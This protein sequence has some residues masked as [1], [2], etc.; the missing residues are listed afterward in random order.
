MS[1]VFRGVLESFLQTNLGCA[2]ATNVVSAARHSHGWLGGLDGVRDILL[3]LSES[4]SNTT[5]QKI[6]AW[7]TNEGLRLLPITVSV[8][9]ANGPIAYS[10]EG[11]DQS[12]GGDQRTQFIGLTLCALAHETRD[13]TAVQLF[14]SCILQPL[15]EGASEIANAVYAQLNDD[16]NIRRILNEGA[17]RGLTQ[18]FLSVAS[19][20]NLPEGDREWLGDNLLGDD[21]DLSSLT[22]GEMIGGM[23]KWLVSEDEGLYTTRSALVCR[24]ALYLQ[25]I[26][27]RIGSVQAMN[28]PGDFLSDL[29]PKSV[30]LVTK[31]PGPADQLILRAGEI[32][33]FSRTLH[34]RFK[35]AG[36]MLLTA[37]ESQMD[38]DPDV[39][40]A[41]F[42]HIQGYVQ[43]HF[44][45]EY[46]DKGSILTGVQVKLRKEGR[47]IR[48][49][50]TAKK[51]AAIYFPNTAK[52]FAPCYS[53]IESEELLDEARQTSDMILGYDVIPDE[54][55]LFRAVT[56][57]IVIAF[58]GKM[59]GETFSESQHSISLNLGSPTWLESMCGD[60]DRSIRIGW[61]Y[62]HAVS[63]LAAIHCAVDPEMSAKS[64]YATIGWCEGIY[65]VVPSL[66]L[67]MKPSADAVV[68]Q[69]IDTFWGN[70]FAYEDGSIH[71]AITM[72]L[73]YDW[74]TVDKA[75]DEDASSGP[76]SSTPWLGQ[77]HCAPPDTAISLTIERAQ[78]YGR[79]DICLVIRVDGTVVG[80]TGI[81]D[82]LHGLVHG[83]SEPERCP[84]HRNPYRSFINVKTSHWLS[85]ARKKP[86]TSENHTFIP[87]QGNEHW[88]LFLAGET[89]YFDGRIAFRCPECT[90]ERAGDH[91]VIIGYC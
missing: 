17:A 46:T 10:V 4:I 55:A 57:A 28:S 5:Q 83:Y 34:Y 77:A 80:S 91:S 36:S 15:F 7:T 14:R 22:E 11:I 65:S 60:L 66:F 19:S 25:S 40:Q 62:Q 54:V 8:F 35:T 76:T 13:I 75:Y 6:R 41:H 1:Q 47:G 64:H 78:H 49:T 45:V 38:R 42:E 79:A 61:D 68:L 48:S 81:K 56:A 33:S 12:F 18:V 86:A 63:R 37:S 51:I 26:G 43:R 52:I 39:L 87:V 59:G 20:L 50:D 30:V 2:D 67:H 44:R 3:L 53:R 31:G 16:S 29:A 72:V 84:G 89:V 23:L 82:V 32:S 88:A 90:R 70:K 27:F 74:D 9:T 24:M 73:T 58:I 85:K 21:D 69:C 71:S